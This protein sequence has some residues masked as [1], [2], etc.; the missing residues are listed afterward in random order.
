MEKT[1]LNINKNIFRDI[2][3]TPGKAK[4][5][6]VQLHRW[7]RLVDYDQVSVLVFMFWLTQFII[8]LRV[9]MS[10]EKEVSVFLMQMISYSE[11]TLI[12]RP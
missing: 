10:P 9:D 12:P 3:M 4:Q 7:S 5:P 11:M 2:F 6:K 1:N 8:L